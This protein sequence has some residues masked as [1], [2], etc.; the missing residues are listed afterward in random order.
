MKKTL[1]PVALLL[2]ALIL[3][4]ACGMPSAKTESA[5]SASETPSATPAQAEAAAPS[6]TEEVPA[7]PLTEEELQKFT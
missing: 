2:A 6:E 3:L 5:Q 4:S 7:V 1:M